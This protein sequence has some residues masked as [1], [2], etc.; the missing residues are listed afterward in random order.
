MQF[1][2]RSVVGHRHHHAVAVHVA[3]GRGEVKIAQAPLP[4]G[5]SSLEENHG[6]SELEVVFYVAVL[7]AEHLKCQLVQRVIRALAYAQRKPCVA[8]FHLPL[9]SYCLG[10]A[11]ELLLFGVVFHLQQQFLLLQS[12]YGCGFSQFL[13]PFLAIRYSILY[14][15][16]AYNILYFIMQNYSFFIN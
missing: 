1:Q 13:I 15:R 11:A 16:K 6:S 5:G 4:P 10:L 7:R 14:L 2:Y 3:H 12:L 8:A 9:H